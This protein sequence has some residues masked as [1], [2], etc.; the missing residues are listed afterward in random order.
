MFG[1]I[2]DVPAP[3]DAYDAV[4]RELGNDTRPVEGLILHL[5]RPTAD[6]FQVIEVWDSEDRFWYYQRE[7][8]GP[9][10]A[11]MMPGGSPPTPE[12]GGVRFEV[13]GLVIPGAEVFV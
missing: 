9:L 12:S 6:G 11:K 10:A 1:I 5:A 4:H 13:R 3:I 8:V 2:L 7:V